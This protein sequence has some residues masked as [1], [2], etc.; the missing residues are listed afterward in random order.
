[1]GVIDSLVFHDWSS[2]L[3]LENYLTPA[4]AE[5]IRQPA[6]QQGLRIRSAWRHLPFD[7]DDEP[8][9]TAANADALLAQL[10]ADGRRERVVLGYHDGLLAT[11]H[12]IRHAAQAIVRAAND[13]TLDEWVSR[14]E[15]L[16]AL[17]LVGAGLPDQAAGEIYRLGENPRVVGVS[18]GCN[19]LGRPFGDPIYHP[20]FRAAS[21]LRLPVVLQVGSDAVIDQVTPAVAGG[22]PT[23]Y[24]EFRVLGCQSHMSHIGSMIFGSVFD[25]F[26]E[27]QVLLVGGG[28]SWLPG[29]LWGL[30]YWYKMSPTES[31]WMTRLPLEYFL[32][33]FY[34]STYGFENTPRPELL[35]NAL[36]RVPDLPSRV[37]YA[38]G[39]PNADSVDPNRVIAMLPDVDEE[40]L[41]RTNAL[42]CFRWPDR[43]YMPATLLATGG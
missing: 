35:G 32:D 43:S 17:L 5:W 29:Y 38:S 23:T 13:W 40:Q 42:E 39:I 8:A 10:F 36:G 16:Y 11:A 24:G 26:P 9:K 7:G 27:L 33:H 25:L 41:F 18:L 28:A 15:R 6:E 22:Q 14:D 19:A 31:P 21:D 1:M 4:Y 34:V 2:D 3:V 37:L 12:P 30:D 20:L